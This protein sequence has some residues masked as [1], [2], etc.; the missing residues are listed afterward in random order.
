MLLFCTKDEALI[1][2]WGQSTDWGQVDAI[3]PDLDQGD[4]D[5]AFQSI[6]TGIS[7]GEALCIVAYGDDRC[8]GDRP[9]T[10]N[11]WSWT[12]AAIASLLAEAG[13]ENGVNGG[14]K[15]PPTTGAGALV[16]F[17]L[18]SPMPSS[19]S[20]QVYQQLETFAAKPFSIWTYG[21]KIPLE[22]TDPPV[23]LPVPSALPGNT[24]TFTALLAQ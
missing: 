21:Y 12:A 15:A 4:A 2:A 23:P 13:L 16:L 24:T 5:T 19:F 9:G 14:W 1:A 8:I 17:Q 22:L 20:S 10:A 18:V 7:P 11:A 6:L 3:R